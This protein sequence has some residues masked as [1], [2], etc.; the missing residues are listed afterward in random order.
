[1]EIAVR[2]C[3]CSIFDDCWVMDSRKQD[4]EPV[5]ACPAEWTRF[6]ERPSPIYRPPVQN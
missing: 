6:E 5:K 1:M 2:A 3:Y 4:P